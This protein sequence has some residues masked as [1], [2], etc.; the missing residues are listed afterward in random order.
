MA[1]FGLLIDYE[2]CCVCHTC[3]VA[4]QREHGLDTDVWGIHVHQEG[5]WPIPGTKRYQYD[6]IP[7]PTELCDLCADRT[8]KGKL[9]T[10]VKHCQTG[11]M[12]YGRVED[13]AKK[14][15][16]KGK[17]VLFVPQQ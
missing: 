15:A 6:C 16:R 8:S 11:C 14:L 3:E 10:C 12:E 2:Y 4:C 5:P 7:V 9:P 17:Q 1:D 13:L